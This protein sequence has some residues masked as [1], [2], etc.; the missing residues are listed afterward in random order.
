MADNDELHEL[1]AAAFG[2]PEA[3]SVQFIEDACRKDPSLKAS[4]TSFLGDVQESV[5]A[6]PSTVDID[7]EDSPPAATGEVDVSLQSVFLDLDTGDDPSVKLR[8]LAAQ[9]DPL[10]EKRTK[11]RYKVLNKIGEGGMGIVVL[12]Y[13]R[14][15]NS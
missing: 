4:L 7:A 15:L 9:A 12:A 2:K 5:A 11:E 13:D 3:E 1:F 6:E 14:D 10:E 8:P